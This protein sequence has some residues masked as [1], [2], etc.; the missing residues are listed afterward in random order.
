MCEDK[1]ISIWEKAKDATDEFI[2]KM[3]P[4]QKERAFKGNVVV[5]ND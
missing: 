2:D 3:T 5:N 4:K 1:K